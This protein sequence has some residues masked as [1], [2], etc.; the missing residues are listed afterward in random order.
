MATLLEHARRPATR[1]STVLF[2]HTLS[3]APTTEDLDAI[4]VADLPAAVRRIVRGS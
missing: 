3:S 4:P 1:G 2:W